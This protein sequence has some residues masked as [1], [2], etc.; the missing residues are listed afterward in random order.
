M[1][2]QLGGGL[3]TT[4]P[5]PQLDSDTESDSEGSWAGGAARPG[6]AA[7]RGLDSSFHRRSDV[8]GGEVTV[9]NVL[10]DRTSIGAVQKSEATGAGAPKGRKMAQSGW[11]KDPGAELGLVLALLGEK[12]RERAPAGQSTG[13]GEGK[14]E[15][16]ARER[17]K[18][19]LGN[20]KIAKDRSGS[21]GGVL[22]S[23]G[24]V[25][26]RSSDLTKALEESSR[27][28][29]AGPKTL[30]KPS[31][32]SSRDPGT[33]QL[34]S[35]KE[36]AVSGISATL[37]STTTGDQQHT[38]EVHKGAIENPQN[39]RKTHISTPE[40]IL[41]E[42]AAK[43]LSKSAISAAGVP[44]TTPKDPKAILDTSPSLSKEKLA[45]LASPETSAAKNLAKITIRLHPIGLTPAINPRYFQISSSQT[46]ATIARFI[47]KRLRIRTGVIYLYIQN[48]FTP[49][50]D[51][52]VGDL[53]ALFKTN[54]E[55][56][57]NYCET[58]A[59]G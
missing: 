11:P 32:V 18:D 55:L 28:P 38:S 36:S 40:A 9:E 51:E 19:A 53:Y 23:F 25:L 57:V 58:V 39:S 16:G 15:E 46:V 2:L 41:S 33:Y 50:P 7:L 29:T 8:S 43:D 24:G 3:Y 27:T 26:N 4:M 42:S 5:L 22:Q 21:F 12:S 1:V 13:T 20:H 45:H 47:T 48:S 49:T 52:T 6:L 30:E 14:A 59:F 44:I 37:Y 34:T 17:N 10:G 56:V 31:S 35:G 54:N